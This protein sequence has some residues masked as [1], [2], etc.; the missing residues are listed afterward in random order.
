MRTENGLTRRAAVTLALSLWAKAEEQAHSHSPAGA[1]APLPTPSSS[2]EK[3]SVPYRFQFL[4]PAEANTV[5]RFAAVLI[6]ASERSG[7]A[8]AASVDHYIDLVLSL[9]APSLQRTWRRGLA[10]WSKA[11]DPA[12]RF[13]RL[14]PNEFAPQSADERFFVLFKSAVTAA[15]Y[16]SEEGITKELGYQGLGF[17]REYNTDPMVS[18][19]VPPGYRPQLRSRS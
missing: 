18:F 13:D 3:A 12:A 17:L 6:P 14:V 15:F 8:A 16:T 7:G 19:A 1:A 2:D 11:A 9:A 5:R 10:A 4:S